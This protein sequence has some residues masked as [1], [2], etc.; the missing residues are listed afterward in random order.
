[1]TDDDIPAV[2]ALM[3]SLSE[4]FIVHESAPEAQAAFIEENNDTG[5]RRLVDGGM[6]YR[7]A[8]ID[9]VIAGFIALR[10]H[11]HVFHMFVGKAYQRNGLATALWEKARLAGLAGGNP[12]LFTVNA[13]NY[14]VPVYERLGF[15]R[16]GSMQCK[17]GI[18]YNPM[19][20]D[21]RAH[22]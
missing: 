14:A 10:D 12:G 13:S 22:D 11:R 7:V 2:A 9:S 1:M 5:I 17:N 18:Y 3:R 21:G 8:E 20:L 4:E 16:T 15:S 6:V 19:Q